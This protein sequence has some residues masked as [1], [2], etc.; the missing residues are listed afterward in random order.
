MRDFVPLL[1]LVTRKFTCHH[2]GICTISNRAFHCINPLSFVNE[3]GVKVSE[4]VAKS[5]DVLRCLG[6]KNDYIKLYL[7]EEAQ[8]PSLSKTAV[9]EISN[10]DARN[11][12][13]GKM[14]AELADVVDEL[15]KEEIQSK[16]T[17]VVLRGKSRW[18]CAG[19]DLLVAKEQLSS[20]EGGVAM[21]ALMTD[22]LTRFRRLPLVSVAAIEGGAIGGGAELATACDFRLMDETAFIQFV[23]SRMGVSPGIC[24]VYIH[25]F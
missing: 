1:P 4:L 9:I 13:S 15:E 20:R 16:V 10:P 12:F 8:F 21:G 18:F 23:Q 3:K 6:R 14:M 25:L 5:K 11:A 19:A 22:T 2:H 7:P 17:C 24:L